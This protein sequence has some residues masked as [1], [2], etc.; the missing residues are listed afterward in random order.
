MNSG[1]LLSVK[2][3]GLCPQ[4]EEQVFCEKLGVKLATVCLEQKVVLLLC[5]L[6][7]THLPLKSLFLSASTLLS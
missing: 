1:T 6:V 3:L 7:W 2:G 4:G 5:V